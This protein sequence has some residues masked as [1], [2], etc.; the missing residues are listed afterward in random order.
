M[1]QSLL[2]SHGPKPLG[3]KPQLALTQKS[4]VGVLQ[5]SSES[6]KVLNGSPNVSV[7]KISVGQQEE[8]HGEVHH[9]QQ[10]HCQSYSMHHY[11]NA[12]IQGRQMQCKKDQ[13]HVSKKDTPIVEQSNTV[14]IGIVSKDTKAVNNLP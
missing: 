10:E 3:S 8:A 5:K 13:M 12:R 2:S 14:P 4:R 1:K 11:Q 9:L 7:K 6:N